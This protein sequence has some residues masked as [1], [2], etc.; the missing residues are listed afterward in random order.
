MEPTQTNPAL[1]HMI[2]KGAS[3]TNPMGN[4]FIIAMI[5]K[6][7]RVMFCSDRCSTFSFPEGRFPANEI[8][9]FLRSLSTR[10]WWI[11][12]EQNDFTIAV[13]LRQLRFM[14][15]EDAPE[16]T[17]SLSTIDYDCKISSNFISNDSI[18]LLRNAWTHYLSA[19]NNQEVG[20]GIAKLNFEKSERDSFMIPVDG[21]LDLESQI[22]LNTQA[23]HSDT[24]KRKDDQE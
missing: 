9:N 21:F 8:A 11:H 13:N 24:P 5:S 20:Q 4:V 1:L 12:K 23:L 16:F 7:N 14:S 18:D 2:R 3:T 6:I 19:S 10:S 15:T 22:R 17:S